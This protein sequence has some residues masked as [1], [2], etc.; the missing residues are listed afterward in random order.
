VV[1]GHYHYRDGHARR[2]V[3][4]E[5]GEHA[6]T[7][8]AIVIRGDA[9]HL[10]LPDASVDLIVTSPPY[11]GLRS[12]TDAGEHY[13][14]QI[15]SEATPQEWL[16]AMVACTAEW[17]RVLK[18]SG[19]IFVNLGDKFSGAQAQN[20][21]RPARGDSAD[22][23]RR[24]NPKNTGIPAKSLMGLPWRYAIAATDQLGL[25]LRRDIVWSK[26][27]GLPESVT[28]RC[29]SSHEY[30]FHLVKQPRYYAAVD[31]IREPQATIGERH[32]GRSGY[33]DAPDG[34]A[35]SF[36]ERALNPL[37]KLPGSVWTI[38]SQPLTVPAHLGIDHFAC[39]DTATEILTSHGW[40]RHD[41]LT[42]GDQVAGYDLD[43]NTARWTECTA[44]NR[45]NYDGEMV[46]VESRDLSM[47]LT[48]NHR[49]IVQR[50]DTR[51]KRRNPVSVVRADEL[52]PY[53]FIPRDAQWEC[54]TDELTIHRS[55]AAILGWV[56]AEGWYQGR[57]VYLS[58]SL[59]VNAPHVAEI[60]QL[61]PDAVR[62]ERK[63][64]YQGRPWTEVTWKLN[65]PIAA[66]VQAHMPAKLLPWWLLMAGDPERHAVLDAFIA[67]DG[68]RRPDGRI[69]IFQKH[70]HNL[71][72]L[73]ATAVTLGYKTT[74]RESG[75]RFV[76]YLTEGGRSVTLRGT[77]GVGSKVRREHYTGTVWCPTT[78][79][80]TFIARRNGSVFVTGNSFPMEL[81]RRII[82]GWSPPG[83]CVACGEGRRPVSDVTR[84][85]DRYH[86]RQNF[87]STFGQRTSSQGKDESA[88]Q[89]STL[90]MQATR[91][92]TGYA[93]AC[94]KPP[95]EAVCSD[96]SRASAGSPP[97]TRPAVVLDPF[98]GT[99]TTALVA[100]MHGRLGL[101]FDL[102]HDYSRLAA[103]RCSDPAQR[104]AAM[105]VPKPPPIPDGME[106]L[107]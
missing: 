90:H 61:I 84:K 22:F 30:V 73:Q 20:D 67:G 101:S 106:A 60:D 39:V 87:G 63:R 79:T 44:V 86:A 23:W 51:T 83:V 9:R 15:G 11:F 7:L 70:R 45:Y 78:G 65:E 2:L 48:P 71:D 98:G 82:L 62:T 89:F 93:C 26:P 43:T 19:S 57:C 66:L 94:Y 92:I 35:R 69:G 50:M 59:D 97:P 21:G 77:A 55:T 105:Q 76:L 42:E 54:P 107:F 74:L 85:I 17:V 53:H 13:G 49:T 3:D 75:G 46:A 25:I 88:E 29:R 96:G 41:Q 72:I 80:G 16:A 58:Q 37:G 102:S 99:G 5:G 103:W 27:N 47:R 32:N 52:T 4:L 10:P 24:T 95:A 12:Y 104:A 6:V 31:E 36:S 40:L 1:H 33:V 34:I 68:H 8:P 91:T 81:P 100:A 18:P 64:T 38:P 14:G 56:A 28:D